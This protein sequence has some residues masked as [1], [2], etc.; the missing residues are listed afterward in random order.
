MEQFLTPENVFICVVIIIALSK[1]HI[2]ITKE[3]LDRRLE[4]FMPRDLCAS[5]HEIIDDIKKKI[6][7]IYAFLLENKK[8]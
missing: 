8:R 2:F 1:A 7:E 3:D 4:D 6:D 5:K